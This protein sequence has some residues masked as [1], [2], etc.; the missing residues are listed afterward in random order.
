MDHQEKAKC[1]AMAD[2][3]S[4]MPCMKKVTSKYRGKLKESEPQNLEE[5]ADDLRNFE[6]KTRTFSEQEMEDCDIFVLNFLL[7]KQSQTKLCFLHDSFSSTDFY[8][9]LPQ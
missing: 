5:L 3:E 4:C 8:R 6:E 2:T 9:L 1:K 7:N